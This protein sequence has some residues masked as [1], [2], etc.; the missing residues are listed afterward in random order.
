MGMLNKFVLQRINNCL[1]FVVFICLFLIQIF[2]KANDFNWFPSIAI[3]SFLLLIDMIIFSY[4]KRRNVLSFRV[5]FLTFT[6]LFHMGYSWIYLF[7]PDF[8]FAGMDFSQVFNASLVFNSYLTSLELIVGLYLGMQIGDIR[9]AKKV[10]QKSRSTLRQLVGQL[11]VSRMWSDTSYRNIGIAILLISLPLRVYTDLMRIRLG[12]S[13]G[14]SATFDFQL[15]GYL[16]MLSDMFVIGIVLLMIYYRKKKL[17]P[18]L[19]LLTTSAYLLFSMNSGS[20]GTAMITIVVLFFTYNLCVRSFKKSTYAVLA[21]VGVLMASYITTIGLNRVDNA[22]T[23]SGTSDIA[24]RFL[25]EFGGTQLTMILV[26][27][28]TDGLNG[29]MPSHASGNTYVASL[30]S[31]LPNSAALDSY[32]KSNNFQLQLNYPTIGGSYL[33]ELYYN[34]GRYSYLAVFI[35]GYLLSRFEWFMLDLKSRNKLILFA[36]TVLIARQS[37]WW[38]RDSSLVF[39]RHI[40]V[41]TMVMVML[42]FLLRMFGLVHHRRL[43]ETSRET[44]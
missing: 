2:V 1:L 3:V 36:M 42:I 40:I 19:L 14:Y 7:N 27:N 18:L 25:Q 23:I 12:A 24:S 29:S 31:I 21:I 34:F 26:I 5:I 37:L 38:I 44:A 41:G 43:N 35:I 15:N 13:Q 8:S 11:N 30:A 16:S 20:R 39:P 9:N 22:P 17:I 32:V 10:S 28:Q 33:A 6:F 4:V